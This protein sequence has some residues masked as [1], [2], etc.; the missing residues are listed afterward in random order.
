MYLN[1]SSPQNLFHMRLKIIGSV[2][3]I[4]LAK[5]LSFFTLLGFFPFAYYVY[6]SWNNQDLIGFM[7]CAGI[8]VF[9]ALLQV[10]LLIK[11]IKIAQLFYICN[12]AVV[13]VA[14]INIFHWLGISPTWLTILPMIIFSSMFAS[15]FILFVCL[16]APHYHLKRSG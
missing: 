12:Y 1:F 14:V 6:K 9:V 5:A 7:L 13:T 16:F 15:L 10:F 8:G 4:L 2:L 11:N 3:P